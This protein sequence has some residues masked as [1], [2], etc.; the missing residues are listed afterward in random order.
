[1]ACTTV[2]ID[3]FWV[4]WDLHSPRALKF[5]STRL[6]ISSPYFP[7][8]FDSSLPSNTS[9][10]SDLLSDRQSLKVIYIPLIIGRL[11]LLNVSS[12]RHNAYVSH[13]VKAG[14]QS[15]HLGFYTFSL[16]QMVANDTHPSISLGV[17][18]SDG[19]VSMAYLLSIPLRLS[20]S[21]HTLYT[22]HSSMHCT[23][24]IDR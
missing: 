20:K 19:Y 2:L 18:L 12:S 13:F 11:S 24:Y 8:A 17:S 16:V 4:N 5:A 7:S 15:L 1:M 9:T 22:M 21:Q 14:L 23:V 10:V 3:I 6:C